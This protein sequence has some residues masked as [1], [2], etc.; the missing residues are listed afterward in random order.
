LSDPIRILFDENF[1][2]PVVAK[3]LDWY[4]EEKVEIAHIF[5]FAKS[6]ETDDVWI[7]RLATG[8]WLLITTDRAKR[9]GGPKLPDLCRDHGVSHVLVGATIQ[10][11]KQFERVRAI[12]AV[13]PRVILAAKYPTKGTRFSLRY[14]SEKRVILIQSV[15][16]RP[17]PAGSPPP[18][19]FDGR[20]PR[21][22]QPVRAKRSRE[23]PLFEQLFKGDAV[24]QKP[25]EKTNDT[26]IT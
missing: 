26:G 11:A 10:K 5:Q 20:M 21:R 15:D 17:R 2:K 13:W 9:C 18:L 12:L 3:F 24:K 6:G 16:N 4:E 25:A 23:I 22:Q 14:D 1:G 19:G 8:G 7:P